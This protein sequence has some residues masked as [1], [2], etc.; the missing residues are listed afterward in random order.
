MFAFTGTR[1][2]GETLV[3]WNMTIP[4]D[5]AARFERLHE[6]PA[7]RKVLYGSKSQVISRLLSD[8]L[9]KLE[10][11]VKATAEEMLEEKGAAA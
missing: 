6:H 2:R 5:L 3:R 11:E 10:S 8:Y 1:R 4:L 7:Y 9:D